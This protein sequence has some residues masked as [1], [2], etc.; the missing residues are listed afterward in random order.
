MA[1]SDARPI[2][3]FIIYRVSILVPDLKSCETPRVP[4]TTTQEASRGKE[5]PV[6]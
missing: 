2:K 4:L 5:W 1:V 6:Y 3:I